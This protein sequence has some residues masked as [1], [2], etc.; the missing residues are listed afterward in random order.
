MSTTPRPLGRQAPP[1][2][3]RRGAE[4]MRSVSS[5]KS[6]AP[7]GSPG[8]NTRESRQLGGRL[9]R[10]GGKEAEGFP[11]W[12]APWLLQSSGGRRERSEGRVHGEGREALPRVCPR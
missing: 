7:P 9:P 6:E 5:D 1:E 4:R 12:T 8:R 11:R 10:S 3:Q 2:R